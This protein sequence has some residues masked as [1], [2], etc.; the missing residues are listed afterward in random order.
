MKK[1]NNSGFTLI[2]VL[3][4]VLIIGILTSVALPQY[5]KAVEKTRAMKGVQALKDILSAQQVYYETYG[6][7]TDDLSKLDVDVAIPADF[8][9][10]TQEGY[11]LV[12]QRT[13]AYYYTLN[14]NYAGGFGYCF[15]GRSEPKNIK[16]C[17]AISLGDYIHDETAVRYYIF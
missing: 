13:N 4:V 17:Q 7:Y 8:K 12:I 10:V 11:G 9:I 6:T 16:I 5:Q 1:Q 14:V 15:T 2:E 3:I